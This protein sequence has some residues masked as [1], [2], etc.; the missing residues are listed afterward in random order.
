MTD[1]LKQQGCNPTFVASRNG[2]L[3]GT[4]A[5]GGQ[6]TCTVWAA[7][8]RRGLGFSAVQGT[9]NRDDNTE[10]FDTHPD[11]RRGFKP[12]VAPDYTTINERTAG[13]TVPLKFEV[14]GLERPKIL[15]EN[16][17]FSRR[18]DCTTLTVPSI[19]EFITPRE[20]PLATTSP[21]NSGH[22]K[23]GN[24]TWHYN[25]KTLPEW[26]GTCREVVIT[27]SDGVQ[28][29]AFFRFTEG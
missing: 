22:K 29:R 12:P 23:N 15:A 16:S 17:P 1:G 25:W 26:A 4:Q 2:I 13:A 11:C 3:A 10:A 24:N 18:V 19:G 28:H 9:T 21:G 6:D 7:F 27:R 8:S 20:Y 5:L 14:I